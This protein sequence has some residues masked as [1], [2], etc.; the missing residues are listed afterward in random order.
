MLWT[1]LVVLMAVFNFMR[2]S[3]MI[4]FCILVGRLFAFVSSES[5]WFHE[6]LDGRYAYKT[7]ASCALMRVAIWGVCVEDA[8]AQMSLYECPTYYF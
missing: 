4:D 2:V 7:F 3:C 1:F 5:V 8:A 6:D